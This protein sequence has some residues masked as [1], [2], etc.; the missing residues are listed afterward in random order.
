MLALLEA[1]AD[2]ATRQVLQTVF[3]SWIAAHSD[4]K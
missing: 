4:A 2:L 1:L 3:S